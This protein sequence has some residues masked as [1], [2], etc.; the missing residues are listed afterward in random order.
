MSFYTVD[1][2]GRK[3]F[4][5]VTVLFQTKEFNLHFCSNQNPMLHACSYQLKAVQWS[6][7]HSHVHAICPN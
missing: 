1:N 7:K 3:W 6:L 2:M 5:I 4:V